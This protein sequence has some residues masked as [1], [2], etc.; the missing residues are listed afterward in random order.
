MTEL[1]FHELPQ[2]FELVYAKNDDLSAGSG[3]SDVGLLA[4]KSQFAVKKP[5]SRPSN[6]S[7]FLFVSLS[8]KMVLSGDLRYSESTVATVVDI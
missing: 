8:Q 3:M 6:G 4:L 7:L 1:Q 5:P 2:Y